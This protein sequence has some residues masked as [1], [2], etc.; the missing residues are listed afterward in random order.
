MMTKRRVQREL[1][2][3]ESGDDVVRLHEF[4]TEFGYFP[5]ASLS[6]VYRFWTPTI[7]RSPVSVDRYDETTMNALR[8][9]QR[10]HGLIQT[11]LVDNP[12][13]ILL[14]SP[15]C[16]VPDRSPEAEAIWGT[17][18]PDGGILYDIGNFSTDVDGVSLRDAVQTAFDT[19]APHTPLSFSFTNATSSIHLSW[20]AGDHGDGQAFDGPGGQLAHSFAPRDGRVHFDED[21]TWS[22]DTPA[23]QLDLLSVALHEIGHALGL[24]HSSDTNSVMYPVINYRAMKRVL[25]A[26]DIQAIRSAYARPFHRRNRPDNGNHFWT[27][28][29]NEALEHPWQDEEVACGVFSRQVSGTTPLH[30]RVNTQ[31]GDHFWTTDPGEA[32]QPPWQ[33]EE[34]A[35][36]VFGQ[37]VPGAIPLYRKRNNHNGQ[38]FYTIDPNEAFGDPWIEEGIECYVFPPP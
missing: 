9:F 38:H 1:V 13:L 3:G 11:G 26:T 31:S 14:N 20:W 35:G 28:D 17:A 25:A 6:R 4:L 15:R 5:N 18:W 24:A 22:T 16:G 8:A 30:R 10:N 23:T 19:W 33:D 2:L 12:T 29:P 37:S 34:V 32:T 27:L 36:Y 21:E 7:E